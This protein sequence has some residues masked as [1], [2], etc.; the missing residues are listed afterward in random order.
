MAIELRPGCT[1]MFTGDSITDC[2]RLLADEPLGYGYPVRVA[3][4]WGFKHPTRDVNWLNTGVAGDTTVH[5]ERRWDR[6]VL[7]ARADVVS[8]L[9]GAN[10]VS[11][12]TFDPDGW[13][14]A[15]AEYAERYDRLLRPLAAAGTRLILIEPFI[16]PLTGERRDLLGRLAEM[17]TA[18]RDLAQT[19]HASLLAA[20]GLFAQLSAASGA[21]PW[22]Y[23]GVHLSRAGHAALAAEWLKLVDY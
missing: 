3:G 22:T 20:D 14:M 6:D 5:L 11:W 4:Q 13:I 1:V 21:A 9:I 15:P 16:L 17:I 18:V 19:H 2:G 12:H 10:D 7:S 8:V 23:D